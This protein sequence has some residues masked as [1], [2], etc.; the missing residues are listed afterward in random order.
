MQE[1]LLQT[2]LSIA[3]NRRGGAL[4]QNTQQ[5]KRRREELHSYF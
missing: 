1:K 4:S 2:D 3:I 5:E